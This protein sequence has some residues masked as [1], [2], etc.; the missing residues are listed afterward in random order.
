[1]K[2]MTKQ[3]HAP[4][5]L[6]QPRLPHKSSVSHCRGDACAQG[7]HTSYRL[8]WVITLLCS[9]TS[10]RDDH[11]MGLGCGGPRELSRK[12]VTGMGRDAWG[13][14]EG[15]G[16][17]SPTLPG[18]ASRSAPGALPQGLADHVLV[19]DA[20]VGERLIPGGV[21][22]VAQRFGS[23]LIR[24]EKQRRWRSAGPGPRRSFGHR[25][26]GR[27]EKR[28]HSLEMKGQLVLSSF[29]PSAITWSVL[30]GVAPITA[31]TRGAE[32]WQF[33]HLQSNPTPHPASWKQPAKWEP[34]Q[35]TERGWGLH[36]CSRRE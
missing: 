7:M 13:G 30:D 25:W 27:G 21:Q 17:V 26:A 36:L 28:K 4:H 1:M 18:S 9:A 6:F 2:L 16:H 15:K 29:C 23:Q 11:P 12:I 22:R 5:R 24:L 35:S 10:S 19:G 31:I 32:T 34:W 3:D 20:V 33:F 14:P 8:W